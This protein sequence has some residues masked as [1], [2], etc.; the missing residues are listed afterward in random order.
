MGKFVFWRCGVSS[1]GTVLLVLT[2]FC[3]AVQRSLADDQSPIDVQV[4][5]ERFIC[6]HQGRVC[7]MVIDPSLATEETLTYIARSDSRTRSTNISLLPSTRT[8]VP[9][10]YATNRTGRMRK[11]I[12]N[13]RTDWGTTSEMTGPLM[14][15]FS[16]NFQDWAQ[17]PFVFIQ[18]LIRLAVF[19][20]SLVSTRI[21]GKSAGMRKSPANSG[22]ECA[23]P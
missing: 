23:C 3:P 19:F 20:I 22:Y 12:T 9:R 7:T 11:P 15:S 16:W 21:D 13:I 2:I 6:Q 18:R 1:V 10:N 17:R 14:T 4:V 8:S 5:S